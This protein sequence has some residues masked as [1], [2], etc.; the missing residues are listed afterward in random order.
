MNKLIELLPRDS[1][2]ILTLN[3]PAKLNAL[4]TDLMAEIHEALSGIEKKFNVLVITG[5]QK[6]F[7]AGVDVSEIHAL[8]YEKAYLDDF[9]DHRWESVFNVKIP[10]IAAVSGYALGGGF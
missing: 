2:A 4:S 6:A 9:I 7:A 1:I 3:N 5:D 8:S 10:V